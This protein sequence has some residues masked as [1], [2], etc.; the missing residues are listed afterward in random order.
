MSR[1]WFSSTILFSPSEFAA[2]EIV[3]GQAFLRAASGCADLP[4]QPHENVRLSGPSQFTATPRGSPEH[5]SLRVPKKRKRARRPPT[6][7]KKSACRRRLSSGKLKVVQPSLIERGYA[8]CASK[9]KNVSQFAYI[10]HRVRYNS[11]KFRLR[12]PIIRGLKH[13]AGFTCPE[14]KARL[15]RW[16]LQSVRILNPGANGS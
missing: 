6:D 7:Q 14:V 10:F 1:V 9:H 12:A 13:T 8:P 2:R 3:H 16:S 11:D 15:G 4:Q 5:F